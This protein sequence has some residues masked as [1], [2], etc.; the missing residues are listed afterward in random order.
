[1]ALTCTTV[2]PRPGPTHIRNASAS[3]VTAP[4]RPRAKLSPG[5]GCTEPAD[6]RYSTDVTDAV[7]RYQVATGIDEDAG[8][9]GPETRAA[10]ESE[11]RRG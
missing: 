10:L 1:M 3:R 8:V 7:H 9:Y 5:T 11:T 6:G 2:R 4:S